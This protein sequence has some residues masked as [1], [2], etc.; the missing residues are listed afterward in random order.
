[1]ITAREKAAQ[2]RSLVSHIEVSSFPNPSF[3]FDVLLTTHL[4]IILATDQLN[5]QILVFW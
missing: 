2:T 1:M 3:F 4:S 5:A